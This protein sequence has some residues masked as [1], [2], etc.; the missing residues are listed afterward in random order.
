MV[1]PLVFPDGLVAL[2]A[3]VVPNRLLGVLQVVLLLRPD[4]LLHRGVLLHWGILP[5]RGILLRGILLRG[6]LSFIGRLVE[7][8]WVVILVIFLVLHLVGRVCLVLAP[9]AR[10]FRH[11]LYGIPYVPFVG[12]FLPPILV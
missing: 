11:L 3:A 9:F 6:I 12:E 8:G 5:L 4:I 7:V 10:L 2:A 1:R